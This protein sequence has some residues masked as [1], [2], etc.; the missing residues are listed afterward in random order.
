MNIR[1]LLIVTFLWAGNS[2]ILFAQPL[3]PADSTETEEKSKNIVKRI[4]E[5]FEKSNHVDNN[6]RLD[7]SFIGGPHY[8]GDTKFGIGII[9]SGLFRIDRTDLDISP[10]NASLYGDFTTSGSFMLGIGGNIIFPH[11]LYRLNT[12]IFFSSVPRKYWGIGYDKGQDED[13]YSKYTRKE[14]SVKMD[15]S[16]QII[17]D[18]Y[19]GITATAQ[20]ISGCHFKDTG[21]LNNESPNNT[22]IGGGL[23]I[24]YDTRDF[25]PNPSGGIYLIL[26]QNFYS[27]F[28]GSSS[29]FNKTDF[30]ARYYQKIWK[31]GILAFD[32]QGIFNN[33]NTPWSMLASIGSSYKMRGYYQGQYRDKKLVQTQIELRQKIYKRSGAVVWAGAGNVFPDFNEYNWEQTLPS[34][35]VGYRWEFKNRINVRLDYGIG[36]GQTSFYFN[37]NEAF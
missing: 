13:N 24:S 19:L 33:G 17:K 6:K 1:F 8:S 15:F 12:D 18:T 10:S 23:L 31:N 32:L 35:G 36:K 22:A 7:I 11:D 30:S 2:C 14:I 34:F 5:Y 3:Q 20:H 29:D 21:F 9:A 27:S 26:E 4:Y 25:I 37:I 16:R 28:L